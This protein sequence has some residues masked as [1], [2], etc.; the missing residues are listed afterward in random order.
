MCDV[1][2]GVFGVEFLCTSLMCLL[3][4]VGSLKV[5][6]HLNSNVCTLV[7]GANCEQATKKILGYLN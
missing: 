3:F 2:A 7:R 4:L 1:L 5:V 6:C